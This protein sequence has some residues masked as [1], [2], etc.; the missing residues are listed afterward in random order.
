MVSDIDVVRGPDGDAPLVYV[1]HQQDSAG[2]Y[3]GDKLYIGFDS[4]VAAKSAYLA[5]HDPRLFG[6]VSTVTVN[7]LSEQI[8]SRNES[9]PEGGEPLLLRAFHSHPIADCLRSFSKTRSQILQGNTLVV[10]SDGFG[11]V[12][13]SLTQLILIR[14][15]SANVERFRDCASRDPELAGDLR[16]SIALATEVDR[17]LDVPRQ[18]S[19]LSRMLGCCEHFEITD[20]V[21]R[22]VPIFVMDDLVRSQLP[23]QKLFHNVP[24]FEDLLTANVNVPIR[25]V[26][27]LTTAH[28]ALTKSLRRI[29]IVEENLHKSLNVESLKSPPAGNRSV[30]TGGGVNLV[31]NSG[32]G[33]RAKPE[34]SYDTVEHLKQTSGRA[35][36][37]RAR[38][39]IS[40]ED[41]EA[42]HPRA[43]TRVFPLDPDDNPYD[44]NDEEDRAASKTVGQQVLKVGAK[45]YS[46]MMSSPFR[47]NEATEVKTIVGPDDT[48]SAELKVPRTRSI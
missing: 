43:P 28:P 27:P 13:V 40:V 34:I 9:F 21:V 19:M 16:K 4:A 42:L 46:N 31:Y 15:Q 14:G 3:T 20:G 17:L 6:A 38:Y 11:H 12:P 36:R 44:I 8:R 39:V 7:Y 29:R 32:S 26:S 25:C 10:K 23:A 48:S 24:V 5:K 47:N 45:R 41:L 22:A 33:P 2:S 37:E 35:E 1:V 30:H 18:A